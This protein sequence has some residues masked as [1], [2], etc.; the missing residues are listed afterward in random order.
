METQLQMHIDLSSWMV[1]EKG[2]NRTALRISIQPCV[3]ILCGSLL[4][5][6]FQIGNESLGKV[7]I[8]DERKMRRNRAVLNMTVPPSVYDNASKH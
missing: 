7:I 4:T 2:G 6:N 1:G 3:Y 8:E 5:L